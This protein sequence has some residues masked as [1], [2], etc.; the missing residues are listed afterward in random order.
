[1]KPAKI[2][3]R[4]RV[5]PIVNLISS[6]KRPQIDKEAINTEI[7]KEFG[8]ESVKVKEEEST[9]EATITVQ[10]IK[11]EK[12]SQPSAIIN[13]DENGNL[14]QSEREQADDNVVD[15]FNDGNCKKPLIQ[16]S[17][18]QNQSS[19]NEVQSGAAMPS[20]IKIQ[21]RLR[22]S[23]TLVSSSQK[24]TEVRH[25]FHSVTS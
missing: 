24:T 1:V 4:S 14:N 7:S 10:E 21:P 17:I 22:A 16:K 18:P 5:K 13:V 25:Q 11:E 15:P 20:R 3:L 12:S 6:R 23:R 19:V 2:S 9:V 8:A